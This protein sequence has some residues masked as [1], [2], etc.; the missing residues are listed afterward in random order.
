[1]LGPIPERSEA[2]LLTGCSSGIGRAAALRLATP[3]GDDPYAGFNA[4]VG[5]ITAGAYEGPMRAQF[6]QP[7]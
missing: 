5:T 6:P 3:D 1:M 2:V 4:A 7:R